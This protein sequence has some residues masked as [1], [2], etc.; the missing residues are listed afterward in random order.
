MRAIS[1]LYSQKLE[2]W[3]PGQVMGPVV[4]HKFLPPQNGS[5]GGFKEGDVHT[6]HLA[7]VVQKQV[8]SKAQLI[9]PGPE[10]LLK[11]QWGC[12]ISTFS[13]L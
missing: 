6:A 13:L 1:S 8:L 12:S 5:E 3:H 2:V 4:S 11:L 10:K 9:P 7:S